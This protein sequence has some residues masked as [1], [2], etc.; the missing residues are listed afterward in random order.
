MKKLIVLFTLML[1][2]ASSVAALD[3]SKPICQDNKLKIG[4]EEFNV[5]TN[6]SI[7]SNANNSV[8]GAASQHEQGNVVWETTSSDS[9]IEKT[10]INKTVGKLS[11]IT[12]TIATDNTITIK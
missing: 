9:N 5:S 6:V 12:V 10:T 1:M 3:A 11:T 4:G 8:Y 7:T 2:P